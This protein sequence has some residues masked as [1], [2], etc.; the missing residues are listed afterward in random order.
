[1]RCSFCFIFYAASHF[2]FADFVCG[3]C[4]PVSDMN[5]FCIFAA[6]AVADNDGDRDRDADRYRDGD[7]NGD[8]LCADNNVISI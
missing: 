1:M 4:R 3:C 6:Y 8:K 2:D 5:Y 7:G